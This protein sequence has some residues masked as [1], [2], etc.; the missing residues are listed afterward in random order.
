MG[1]MQFYVNYFDMEIKT[2]DDNPTV[3]LILCTEQNKRMV[4]YTLGDKAKQI[5]ASK[6]QFTLPTAEELEAELKKEIQEFNKNKMIAPG[7]N[8]LGVQ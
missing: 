5:F 3:G 1:Q 7:K 8:S 2:K 4:K 6:Y